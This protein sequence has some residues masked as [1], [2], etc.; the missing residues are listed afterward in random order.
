MGKGPLISLAAVAY[1]VGIAA[2]G[3]SQPSSTAVA[4]GP[5]AQGVNYAGCMRSHGVPNF[6]DANP[7]GG[8]HMPA[9]IDT[10]SPA[11]LSARS[12]CAKLIPGPTAPRPMAQR[13]KLELLAAAKCMRKHGVN[14]VD[15][16]F[17]GP[18]ITLDVPDQ[19]TIQSPAFAHAEEVCHYPVPNPAHGSPAAP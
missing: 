6:P 14:V 13:Q 7:A 18:Y 8:L 19:A 4:S 16:T 17:Q 15:P 9:S 12:A 5:L 11:Y 1:A 2:C 3:A 10:Q